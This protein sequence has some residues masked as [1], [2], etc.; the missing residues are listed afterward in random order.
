MRRSVDFSDATRELPG[1][2]HASLQRDTVG[3]ASKHNISSSVVD[4]NPRSFQTGEE[5]LA[6]EG[7]EASEIKFKC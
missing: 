2:A 3:P 5:V 1:S 6:K 7:K 4:F